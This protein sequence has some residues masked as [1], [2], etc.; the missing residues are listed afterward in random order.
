MAFCLLMK[1]ET[2][3]I[4]TKNKT[5]SKYTIE[6]YRKDKRKVNFFLFFNYAM[7][8]IEKRLFFLLFKKTTIALKSAFCTN[9]TNNNTQ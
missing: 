8:I 4:I 1:I 2:L 9:F 5:P 7:V 6:L 3:F